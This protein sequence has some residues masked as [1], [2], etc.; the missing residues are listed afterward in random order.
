[1]K[2]V[3]CLYEIKEKEGIFLCPKCGWPYSEG[4]PLFHKK[5]LVKILLALPDE[6]KRLLLSKLIDV[7][8]PFFARSWYRSDGI[9]DILTINGVNIGEAMEMDICS[10]L[11]YLLSHWAGIE[12]E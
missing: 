8:S 6:T 2:C 11:S 12:N 3:N 5:D 4:K 1:M 9:K 7:F 10:G